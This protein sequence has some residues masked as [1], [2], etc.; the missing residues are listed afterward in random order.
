VLLNGGVRGARQG[1]G[2]AA[3]DPTPLQPV[4][5]EEGFRL[6]SETPELCYLTHMVIRV[7][8]NMAI[9]ED[10]PARFRVELSF[11]P[12]VDRR[13]HAGSP[14][15]P[16]QEVTID[17]EGEEDDDDEDEADE[18]GA[19]AAAVAAAAAAAAAAAVDDAVKGGKKDKD[20]KAKGK[21][22]DKEKGGAL[23][24]ASSTEAIYFENN[25]ND[26]LTDVQLL[27]VAQTV[28][29]NR[30]LH[31]SA[32]GLE[33]FLEAAIDVSA[34]EHDP[35][36][37]GFPDES[38]GRLG[39]D[40]DPLLPPP[41]GQSGGQSSRTTTATIDPSLVSGQGGAGSSKG[42]SGGGTTHSPGRGSSSSSAAAA[43]AKG[44]TPRKPKGASG[45]EEAEGSGDGGLL[46]G[47]SS[48]T[49]AAVGIAAL[50]V[51]V[52]LFVGRQRRSS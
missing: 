10:N 47:F 12:G 43:A 35:D 33:Q 11:S 46:G 28:P 45:E 36:D 7:F 44:T 30:S 34:T 15:G 52:V 38:D 8:E 26:A 17:E 4:I 14:S 48:S 31:L 19:A 25:P 9:Q 50:A 51:S 23:K 24:K 32:R 5:D 1:G 41:K 18:G 6:T 27:R 21:G 29:L 2:E 16:L 49:I 37:E 39:K 40:D 22:K 42:K 20:K 3:D 13:P